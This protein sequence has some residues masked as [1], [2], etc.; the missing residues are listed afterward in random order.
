MISER[1]RAIGSGRIGDRISR[2]RGVNTRRCGV[3]GPSSLSKRVARGG[4]SAA[5]L[6]E[7]RGAQ[8][9]AVPLP[10]TVRLRERNRRIVSTTTMHTTTPHRH[11]DDDDY[12]YND[13]VDGARYVWFAS[14]S[15]APGTEG[16]FVVSL[17][18]LNL[19]ASINM[20]RPYNVLWVMASDPTLDTHYTSYVTTNERTNERTNLRRSSSS[21]GLSGWSPRRGRAVDPSRREPNRARRRRRARATHERTATATRADARTGD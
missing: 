8:R 14:D 6:E 9:S 15:A 19:I 13:D 12:D 11:D 3:V 16:N 20:S 18:N 21:V 5:P 2:R 4:A 1:T 17:R 7:S 10:F